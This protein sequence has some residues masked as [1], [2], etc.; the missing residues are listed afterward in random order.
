MKP[1]RQSGMFD[2]K[3]LRLCVLL[4]VILALLGVTAATASPAHFHARTATSCDLC[5]SAGVASTG[6]VAQVFA[7]PAPPPKYLASVV[8]VT[9]RYEL[10]RYQASH[11]RGPPSQSL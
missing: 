7:V 2:R 3:T 8:L 4:A 11:T 6:Q 9:S 5:L 1:V 10:L